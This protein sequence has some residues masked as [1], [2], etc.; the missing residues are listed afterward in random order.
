MT[1]G[2]ASDIGPRMAR[3]GLRQDRNR[4][5]SGRPKYSG[6]NQWIEVSPGAWQ[7]RLEAKRRTA[8]AW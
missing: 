8:A 1:L 2:D 3:I 7:G 6:L 4:P 5:R